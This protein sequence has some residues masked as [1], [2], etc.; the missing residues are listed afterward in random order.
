[1][2]AP[3]KN[4]EAGMP[5]G[6]VG[7]P[8]YSQQP[9]AEYNNHMAPQGGYTGQP[10]QTQGGPP[11]QPMAQ[12]QYSGEQY[13]GGQYF[14]GQYPQGQPQYPNQASYPQ[15][16]QVPMQNYPSPQGEYP[17]QYGGSIPHQASYPEPRDGVSEMHSPTEVTKM[18][19]PH[20]V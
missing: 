9:G 4:E 20:Q 14:G 6:G 18:N 12:E 17:P 13:S 16:Q 15:G 7:A 5:L 3:T 19:G 10:M 1:M 11:Q 8:T 2:G